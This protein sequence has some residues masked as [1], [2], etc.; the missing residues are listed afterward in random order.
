MPQIEVTFDID[1]NGIVNVTAKDR[2]TNKEQKITITASSG[3]SKDEVDRM[4]R[5]AESH[6]DED[7]KRKEE[8]ETRNHADQAIYAAEGLVRE[9]GDK[10]PAADKQAIE[11]AV[12]ELRKALQGSDAAAVTRAM[13]VL[14]SAQH[15]AAEAM[16][17]QAGPAADDASAGGGAAADPGGAA[18]AGSRTNDVI[19][20]EVVDEDKR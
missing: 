10:I 3:L 4:M 5:E 14:T 16:Y 7:R 8:I 9:N 11:S 6:A 12:E 17:R 13:E 18:G 2:A 20:A 19:D 15:K 1:A